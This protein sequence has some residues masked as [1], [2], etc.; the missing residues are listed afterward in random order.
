MIENRFGSQIIEMPKFLSKYATEFIYLFNEIYKVCVERQSDENLSAFYNFP[1]NARKFLESYLF[2]KYPDS[3]IGNHKR[4]NMFFNDVTS[5]AFLQRINN[6]FS[7]G[8]EQ[9]DRLHKPI[10]IGEFKK[11]ASIIIKKIY[12]KD[13]DQFSSLCNSIGADIESLNIH[14][15]SNLSLIEVY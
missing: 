11:D 12:E 3:T 9:P 14:L 4:M 1:N 15:L 8:E 5:V 2:F 13:E 6:E 7:H 10:D